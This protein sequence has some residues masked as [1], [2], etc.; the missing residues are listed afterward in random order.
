MKR[1]ALYATG[2][3]LLLMS[4]LAGAASNVPLEDTAYM[5]GGFGKW[6][7]DSLF[8]AG[9]ISNQ[10]ENAGIIGSVI[11]PLS[12]VIML[13]AVI[14]IVFKSMQHLLVVAQAKD[15]EQSPVS[16]TWA[17]LHM[18]IAI[19]LIMPLP[20]GYSMGQYGAIQVAHMSNTLGNLT[21]SR[22]TDYF[23]LTGAIT[24]PTLP[25]V[26]Q[27]V[28]G[29]VAS[30]M[31]TFLYEKSAKFVSDNGGTTIT[32][33]PRT[34]TESELA[35]VGGAQIKYSAE[36]GLTRS[37]VSFGRSREGGFLGGD[38]TIDDFCG[39]VV[40][41]YTA[42]SEGLLW[43]D[44][45]VPVQ[46]LEVS[47]IQASDAEK[48]QFSP[49]CIGGMDAT[50]KGE[51]EMAIKTFSVAHAK[52]AAKFQD[53]ALNGGQSKEIAELLLWDMGTYFDAKNDS[54]AAEK[55]AEGMAL[56]ADK[57]RSA[58]SKTMTLIT[59]IEGEV[60]TSYSQAIN[61]FAT[62][63]NASTG[64]NFLDTVDRVGWPVLGLYWFQF[65]NFSQ[66]VM[67]SVSVQSIY[68]GDLD[69]FIQTFVDSVGDPQ[70]GVRLQS[71]ILAYRGLLTN[72][73]Q[74][75]RFD[76][77]PGGSAKLADATLSSNLKTFGAATSAL[78][79]REAFPLMRD[80][81]LSNAAKGGMNP[82]SMIEAAKQ[83]INTITRG[84]IFPLIISTL[85]E[86]NLVNALVNTGHNI[87]TVSEIVYGASV[88]A[89]A[90]EGGTPPQKSDTQIEE[91]KSTWDKVSGFFK[92]PIKSVAGMA[93]SAI[94][95]TARALWIVIQ[96]FTTFWFY[97]FLMGLF[98]AFYIPAMIMIQWLIGLV[99]WIIYIAE[100]TVIIP[101][102]GLLFT[103][104]MGQKAFAPQ[105]AQQGF[106]HLL[107]ILVYP[108]LMTI[109]FI[110]GLKVID[111]I[112]MFLVDYLMIGLMNSTDGYVFGLLSLIASL[113]I[114]GLACYQI[115]IR[116]F[117][118][119]LELNDRAMSWI[120]NRQGY[121][122][123]NVEGQVRG[124]FNAAIGK[125]ET[126]KRVSGGKGNPAMDAAGKRG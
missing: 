34:M 90:I 91:E 114:L 58:V 12:L 76:S 31:C 25:S 40:L 30:K 121:G 84:Y 66:Q 101:L 56:E 119:V 1:Y 49:L 15:P 93:W 33:T 5:T 62:Q 17:P 53:Q 74:N 47:D 81:L 50:Y 71:R 117:S 29:I 6:I 86:D 98:L 83:S 99:T 92:N 11:Q 107:S 126:G 95:G 113:F 8:Q 3:S 24:P 111:L 63:R 60:Y 44:N 57:V 78:E 27:A 41:Q 109:G 16:M 108:S 55:Y 69:R 110:I 87:I 89:R 65:T 45:P 52:A 103:A 75:S 61:T 26:Q 122:E 32:I 54:E 104:D 85:R 42:K 94:K 59:D 100:A 21:A 88:L 35:S 2:F 64:N 37:G 68:T 28:N 36:D 18:V 97:V 7:I 79:I 70:L 124:G 67:N 105:T 13:V 72:E 4:A 77:D 120:G 96:D 48:C 125:V 123:G 102:W 80:E 112:S 10:P 43:G 106:V 116:V 9:E 38:Q 82:E 46:R 118:L 20:S 51:K 39:A 23:R 73:L 19:V 115:I 22:A 14:I